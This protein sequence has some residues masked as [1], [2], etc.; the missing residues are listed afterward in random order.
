LT[1]RDPRGG[2]KNWFKNNFYHARHFE[3][4]KRSLDDFDKLR[5]T[6]EPH[7]YIYNSCRVAVAHAGKYSK[8]DPDDASELR[9]LHVAADIMRVLA[10]HFIEAEFKISDCMFDGT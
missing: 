10:R 2:T 9:R 4:L 5:G 6:T 1:Q 8:S 3:S 7:E